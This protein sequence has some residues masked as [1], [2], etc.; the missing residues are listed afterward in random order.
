MDLDALS[1]RLSAKEAEL[2]KIRWSVPYGYLKTIKVFLK[3]IN[4]YG[5]RS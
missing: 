3:M 4:T 5:A 2:T 1:R